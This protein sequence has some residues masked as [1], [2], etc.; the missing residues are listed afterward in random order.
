VFVLRRDARN[1]DSSLASGAFQPS[2]GQCNKAVVNVLHP[3]EAG[4]SERSFARSQRRF[5]HHCEVNAPGLFL[6]FHAEKPSRTRSILSSS[7]PS[8]FE[9]VWGEFRAVNPLSAS[10]SNAPLIPPTSTPVWVF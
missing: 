2:P 9:A 4:I 8:G 1:S 5:R 7:A 6:R 10:I 3:A